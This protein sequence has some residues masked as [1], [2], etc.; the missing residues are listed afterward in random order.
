M[1]GEGGGWREGAGAEMAGDPVQADLQILVAEELARGVAIATVGALTENG[2]N[3]R[4]LELVTELRNGLGAGVALTP[5]EE[6]GLATGAMAAALGLAEWDRA[7]EEARR[8]RDAAQDPEVFTAAERI[9]ASLNVASVSL[10]RGDF[11][12]A[13]ERYESLLEEARTDPT[14]WA[15]H[16]RGQRPRGGPRPQREA[17]GSQGGG[18][19]GPDG[20]QERPAR[21]LVRVPGEGIREASAL[22]W[23]RGR[24]GSP[25]A[26]MSSDAGADA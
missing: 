8:A 21:F 6:Y 17:P 13:A 23:C 26:G 11:A 24:G 14:G 3:A 19:R 15:R 20:A 22:S 5:S 9:S 4:A 16:D 1:K 7:D 25:L 10:A 2:D 18:S 12:G